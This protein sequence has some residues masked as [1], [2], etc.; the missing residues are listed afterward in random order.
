MSAITTTATPYCSPADLL[1]Y[2]DAR[3]V[4]D[5]L[6]DKTDEPRPSRA[7]I[8]DPTSPAG[9]RLNTLLLAASGELEEACVGGAG[10]S[11]ADLASLTGATQASLKRVVAGLAVL[12]LYARRQP[13]AEIPP[14]VQYAQERL[15]KLGKGERV[16]GLVP[17]TEAAVGFEPITQV[18][19]VDPRV[20]RRTVTNAQRYFGNR[21]YP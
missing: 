10:Y 12:A 17:A 9:T 8:L 14:I 16:F 7:A 20:E 4:G 3:T 15:E 5:C 2:V 1:D 19:T 13:T 21:A 6:Q 18:E 11:P